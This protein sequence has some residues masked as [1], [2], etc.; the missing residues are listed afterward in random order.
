MKHL[1][2]GT[3][4]HIDHGKTRLIKVLTGIDTDTLEEEKRRGISI[5]LGFAWYDLPGGTRL[6]VVDVP[7][8]IRFIRTMLAGAAGIDFVLFVVAADDS[9][10]PQT[11]E[12]FDI[13]R[14]LGVRRGI[15][16]ITKI[17][18]VDADTAEL[19]EMEVRELVKGSFLEQAEVVRVSSETGEGIP[20]L[21]K[22]IEAV[23][24]GLE[25]RPEGSL[26]RMP[27]DRVFSVQGFGTVA[28]GTVFSGSIEKGD[29]VEILPGGRTAEIRGIEAH[30]EKK[31]RVFSGQRSALNLAGVA[32]DEVRRGEVLCAPGYFVPT[33]MTDCSFELLDPARPLKRGE[34]VKFHLATSEVTGRIYDIRDNR[35]IQVRLAEPVVTVKGDRFIVR[36]QEGLRTLGGGAILDPHPQKHKR[37]K[38]VDA[39]GIDRLAGADNRTRVTAELGKARAFLSVTELC[40][41][42]TQKRKT[43]MDTLE[44]LAREKR[45]LL[46]KGAADA[47]ALPREKFDALLSHLSVAVRAFHA[48]NPLIR[49]G[50]GK[51]E[52][53]QQCSERLGE[54]ETEA[55]FPLL[56]AEII[57]SVLFREADGTLALADW[58][59]AGSEEDG[60]LRKALTEAF[61]KGGFSPPEPAEVLKKYPGKRAG[62]VVDALVSEG[63]LRRIEGLIFSGPAVDEGLEKIRA[64]LRAG[65]GGTVSDLRQV[66]TTSRKFALPLLNHY[67]SG[68]FLLRQGDLRV[69]A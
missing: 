56:W 61:D 15:V 22:A 38:N 63:R 11:R 9:V 28:T 32:V 33:L 62:Q 8:H 50:L 6:G 42:L 54:A 67:E 23:A 35:L 51:A 3:A 13:L 10:M 46:L 21:R 55:L 68:R 2:L 20:S 4:G 47:H 37:R 66:L 25:E 17:D 7:G 14:L 48:A 39:D 27:V 64:H 57:A 53:R 58:E 44:S 43:V 12:H 34:R 52:T 41:R 1:V 26:F 19:V 24:L 40:A 18:L 16:V 29:K 30:K 49:S 65:G 45:I 69:L 5:N 36:D 59:P 31:D 60:R